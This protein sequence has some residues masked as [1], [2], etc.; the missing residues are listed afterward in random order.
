[1]TAVT[2]DIYVE[3]GASW[4]DSLTYSAIT[5]YEPD[6]VTPKTWVPIDI[7]NASFQMQIRAAYGEHVIL[8]LTSDEGG[9]ITITDGAAGQ[10]TIF[11]SDEQTDTFTPD[12]GKKLKYD[13]EVE[14]VDF[15]VNPRRRLF[16]GAVYV[17]SNI[18]R[19]ET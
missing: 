1:M 3:Q 19:D 5:E 2:R 10:F 15:A 14:S 13:L 8:E 7:S 4:T 11:M 16:Q 12:F 6:G 17:D 18:T 9:G